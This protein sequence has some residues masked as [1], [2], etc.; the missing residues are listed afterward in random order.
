MSPQRSPRPRVWRLKRPPANKLSLLVRGELDWIVMNALEKDPTRRYETAA[1]LAAHVSRHLNEAPGRIPRAPLWM[2]GIDIEWSCRLW[3]EP[4]RLWRRYMV[5]NPLF[6]ARL[7]HQRLRMLL[8]DAARP[9]P[10]LP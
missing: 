1:G 3:Q 9:G 5:G 10:P 2:R 6:L 8:P 7:I 4:N